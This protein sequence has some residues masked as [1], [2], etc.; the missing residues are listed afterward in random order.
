MGFGNIA[1]QMIMFIALLTVTSSL[2]MVF[3]SYI[4]DASSTMKV[5]KDA[6]ID[7]LNT[8]YEII[9]VTHDY[10]LNVTMLFILNTGKTIIDFDYLDVFVDDLF[11]S[12][13]DV[14]KSIESSTNIKNVLL[15]DPK[16]ILAVNVSI[17][18]NDGV[19]HSVDVVI[20]NGLKDTYLF[21]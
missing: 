17:V 19:S 13:G 12:R 9:G 10:D 15:W 3:N 18:L 14:S 21:S 1:S 4:T 8:D 5:K 6:M 11:V 16:E 20:S 2:V 7:K